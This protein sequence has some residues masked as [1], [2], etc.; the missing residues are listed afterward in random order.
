MVIQSLTFDYVRGTQGSLCQVSFELLAVDPYVYNDLTIQNNNVTTN[1]QT[2]NITTIGTASSKPVY[3]LIASQN[4][5]SLSI[6]TM[7]VTSIA[8]GQ[9]LIIDSKNKTVTLDG[10][11][12][13]SFFSG[14]FQTLNVGSNSI[15]VT[16]TTNSTLDIAYQ[17]VWYGL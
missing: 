2:V 8:S 13:Y 11:N 16:G 10:I 15:A 17:S 4:I 9:T 14:N 3:T 12:V 1:P 6:G 5:A 7:T